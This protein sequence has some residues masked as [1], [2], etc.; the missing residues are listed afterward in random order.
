M[1]IMDRLVSS[2]QTCFVRAQI[3]GWG[4]KAQRSSGDIDVFSV[5]YLH[6]DVGT[7]WQW[8]HAVAGFN[9]P[10]KRS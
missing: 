7:V 10:L 3:C 6:A 1:L 9:V 2:A 5:A 8:H 4:R